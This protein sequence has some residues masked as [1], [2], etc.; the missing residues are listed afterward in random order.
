MQTYLEDGRLELDNNMAEH[1]AKNFAV[2]RKNWLF[3]ENPNGAEKTCAMYSIVETAIANG[4]KPEA[5]INWLLENIST[6]VTSEIENLAPWSDKI[7]SN[8][9]RQ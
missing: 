1:M 4:L 6:T 8:L 3:C 9:K 5:Y 2:G 7:P